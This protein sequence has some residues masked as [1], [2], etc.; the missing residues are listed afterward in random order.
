MFKLLT[1]K[2][3]K[4]LKGEHQGYMTFILHL[5]PHTLASARSMCPASSPGCRIGC[6]NTAG[7]AGFFKPNETLESNSNRVQ[8]ARK[9]KTQYFV[10]DCKS[11][12]LDLVSDI[13]RAIKHAN[14]LDLIPVFRLNGTSD[15]VWEKIPVLGYSNIFELFSVVQF[16]DYTKIFRESMLKIPNYY[17][18]FSRSEANQLQVRQARQMGLNIA[19]V[20]DKVPNEWEGLPVIDGDQNDLRFLDPKGVT[21][22]LKA[23]GRSKHDTTGF[24]V[25]EGHN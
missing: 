9:R 17:L 20:F 25:R 3:A 7:R 16:Y 18:V 21:V 11:F 12:M 24:V 19:V 15:I 23:K 2:N 4:T 6:L 13:S 5:A 1:Y 22:G 14:Q 10:Q 8:L